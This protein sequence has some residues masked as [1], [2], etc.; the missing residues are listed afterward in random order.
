MYAGLTAA[1]QMQ[2]SLTADMDTLK[3]VMRAQAFADIHRCR[4]RLARSKKLQVLLTLRLHNALHNNTV[5]FAQSFKLSGS[6]CLAL[7]MYWPSRLHGTS[8]VI[9]SFC[10]GLDWATSQMPSSL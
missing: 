3:Q 7:S 1:Q 4:G 10:E 2:E 8:I 9:A 6:C 5:C